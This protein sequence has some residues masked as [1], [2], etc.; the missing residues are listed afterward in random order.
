MRQNVK[1][2][3]REML[4]AIKVYIRKQK[5][6]N[7]LTLKELEKEEETQIQYMDK[8]KIREEVNLPRR[9]R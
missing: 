3:P 8:Q 2:V 6:V 5:N 9:N 1:A 7:N 4:I